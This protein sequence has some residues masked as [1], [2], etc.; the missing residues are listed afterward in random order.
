MRVAQRYRHSV[1]LDFEPVLLVGLLIVDHQLKEYLMEEAII[2]CGKNGQHSRGSR[3]YLG[4]AVDLR[5]PTLDTIRRRVALDRCRGALP[6]GYDLIDEGDHWHL[7]Y[8][9]KVP[10]NSYKWEERE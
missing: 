2:T 7:E 3:H 9:P 10:V 6:Y 5:I 1:C 8:D 4:L